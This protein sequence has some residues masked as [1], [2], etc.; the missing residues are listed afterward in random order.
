MSYKLGTTRR[1]EK[2][3]RRLTSD[4]KHRIDNIPHLERLSS[5]L[6]YYSGHLRSETPLY[7]YQTTIST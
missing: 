2:D 6:F 3:F 5:P 7:I 1:F 4:L